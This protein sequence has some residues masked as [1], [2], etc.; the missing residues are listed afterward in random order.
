[1]SFKRVNSLDQVGGEKAKQVMKTKTALTGCR[2]E[3]VSMK[4][5]NGGSVPLTAKNGREIRGS[6]TAEDYKDIFKFRTGSFNGQGSEYV[7]INA[8]QSDS[9]PCTLCALE[10]T[11]RLNSHLNVLPDFLRCFFLPDP[12]YAQVL[13]S[14]VHNASIDLSRILSIRFSGRQ[15]ARANHTG[16]HHGS[17]VG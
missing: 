4:D 17:R 14:G 12:S 1:M 3:S 10:Y 6:D 13:A 16:H 15:R 7:D 9:S 8:A 5:K 11:A 2:W